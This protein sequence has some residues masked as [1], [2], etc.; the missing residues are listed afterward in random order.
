MSVGRFGQFSL[1]FAILGQVGNTIS[2]WGKGPSQEG[3]AILVAYDQGSI[4]LDF[5]ICSSGLAGVMQ[6]TVRATS[7]NVAFLA[8]FR[9]FYSDFNTVCLLCLS[10]CL[11]LV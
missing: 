3:L 9:T 2:L 7:P 10:C 6:H 4:A 8:V 1:F 5:R 11:L